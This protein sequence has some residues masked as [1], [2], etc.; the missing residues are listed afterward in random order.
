MPW[1]MKKRRPILAPGWISIPVIQRETWLSDAREDLPFPFIE[2]VGEPVDQNGMEAGVTEDDFQ[3]ALGGGIF[4]EDRIEL[5]P[6]VAEHDPIMMRGER[7]KWR[8]SPR[9]WWRFEGV[10]DGRGG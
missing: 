2:A 5:L 1:S 10:R 4:T 8:A 6:D 9:C 7:Q 3:H